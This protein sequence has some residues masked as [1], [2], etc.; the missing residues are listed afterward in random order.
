MI[1]KLLGKFVSRFSVGDTWELDFG[2]YQLLAQDVVVVDADLLG[3]FLASTTSWYVCLYADGTAVVKVAAHEMGKGTATV[4][5]QHAADRLGLPIEKVSFQYGDTNLPKAAFAGGSMQTV[6]VAAAIAAAADKLRDQL[7][8]LAKRGDLFPLRTFATGEVELKAGGLYHQR[9]ASQGR[10]YADIL[11]AAGRGF[12]EVEADAALPIEVM[13]Y[14]MHSYGAR[15][16]EVR[17]N[18]ITGEVRVSRWVGSFDV[19]RVL[20]PKTTASQLRGGIIM[21]IGAALTEE[22]MF[23]ERTGRTVNATLAE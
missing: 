4:Q 9:D 20:N 16:A 17:V 19:G 7:F 10:S 8:D 2:E 1:S 18:E 6:S 3:Q 13:K 21:S 12:L 11:H 14:S 15:F 22:T 5:I 23:D